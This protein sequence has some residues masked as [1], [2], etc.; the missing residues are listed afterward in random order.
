[1][2]GIDNKENYQIINNRVIKYLGSKHNANLTF[3]GMN[4]PYFAF[5]TKDEAAVKILE[6]AFGIK[7]YEAPKREVQPVKIK[8]S[9]NMLTI[10]A[11]T[12][13]VTVPVA[14]ID[15]FVVQK[16]S[17]SVQNNLIRMES[18]ELEIK[19]VY[20]YLNAGIIISLIFL[21][22]MI[23]MTILIFIIDKRNKLNNQ[24]E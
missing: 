11:K 3:I 2:H 9:G 4:I 23:G 17:Y 14:A 10:T 24:L 6:D 1:M 12:Q 19:I 21:L 15:A 8:L 7:A 16:G 5:L 22:L 20:P 13:G 18:K